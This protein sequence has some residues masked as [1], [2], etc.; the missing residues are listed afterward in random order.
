MGTVKALTECCGM[1]LIFFQLASWALYVF[2][3]DVLCIYASCKCSSMT[4]HKR[5]L[6][7]AFINR[8]YEKNRTRVSCL[9]GRVFDLRPRNP[10]HVVTLTYAQSD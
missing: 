10:C 8:L 5:M 4:I 9:S 2:D 6:I 3:G 1:P 7:F